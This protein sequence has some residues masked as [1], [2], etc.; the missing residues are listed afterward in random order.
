V[1]YHNCTTS[2][3]NRRRR[4]T[5]HHITIAYRTSGR[6][7]HVSFNDVHRDVTVLDLDLATSFSINHIL[8][9]GY[10]GVNFWYN[11]LWLIG[12]SWPNSRSCSGSKRVS[13][14]INTELTIS[15]HHLPLGSMFALRNFTKSAHGVVK[16][17]RGTLN[18]CTTFGS[19]SKFGL[20]P[21]SAC[22]RMVSGR[23][24]WSVS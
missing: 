15:S 3:S 22:L 20:Y 10:F 24:A 1:G 9:W 4:R 19:F 23:S 5:W 2:Q 13:F 18:P 21:I 7:S 12:V 11:R 14:V 8:S 16:S 6:K 17:G